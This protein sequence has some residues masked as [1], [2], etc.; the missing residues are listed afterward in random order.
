MPWSRARIER[1]SATRRPSSRRAARRQHAAVG[2]DRGDQRR[3]RH[4]EGRVPDLR[5]RRAPSAG[6][7]SR[8][9]SSAARSSIGIA[10]PSGVAG[11]IVER[12][13]PRRR[14]ARRAPGPR[15]PRRRCRS[16][17]RRRRWPRSGRRRRA[18][19]ATSPRR[20]RLAAMPSAMTVTGTP[21]RA[22][23]PRGEPAALQQRPRLVGHHGDPPAAPRAACRPARAPCRS[24]RSPARRRCSGSAPPRRRRS[25]PRR[26]RRSARTSRGPRPRSPS[27]SSRSASPRSSPAAAAAAARRSIR[28]SAQRRFTAVGRVAPRARATPRRRVCAASPRPAAAASVTPHRGGDADERRAAHPECADRLGDG[29]HRVEIEVASPRRAAA[30]GRESRTAPSGV[31]AMGWGMVMAGER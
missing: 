26:P 18:R 29:V 10:A 21:A 1:H 4:V 3:R 2:D 19:S 20:S 24:R 9:T 13:A 16:C 22:Q 17:W 14:T 15:A 30:S 11:S 31:Q 7:A 6:R 25:A 28:A 23:L 8:C 12:R 27:A 5:P